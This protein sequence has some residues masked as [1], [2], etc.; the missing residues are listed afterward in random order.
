MRNQIL[1]DKKDKEYICRKSNIA[2]II[3]FV[4]RGSSRGDG[5][6]DMPHRAGS[7]FLY[8]HAFFVKN[9]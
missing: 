9:L 2:K 6:S 5:M 1:K 8:F 3:F 7:K 4:S